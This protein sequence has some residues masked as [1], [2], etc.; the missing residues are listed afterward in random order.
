MS[1]P[2]PNILLIIADDL[3]FSDLG[4]FGSEIKTPNLDRLAAKQGSVRL[5]QFHT[6]S[7]CSPTRSML[8]SGTDHHLAGLGQ[9]A[10]VMQRESIYDDEEGKR[11][12]GYE[13]VL[14]DRVA[15][16]PELLADTHHTW[17]AGKW[18]L[19]LTPETS[20]HARSFHRSYTLLPGA[21]NHYNYT[22]PPPPPRP[23]GSPGFQFIPP[24]YMEDDKVLDPEKDLPKPFYSSDVFVDQWLRFY[25]ELREPTHPHHHR[26]WCSLLTFTAPHWPLQADPADV[27]VYKG[28]YDAGPLALR[29]ARLQ[30][31]YETGLIPE[32][33]LTSARDV[34]FQFADRELEQWSDLTPSE[35][36]LSARSMETYAAMVTRMDTAIGRVLDQLE[37]DG[38]LENTLVFFA[39]DNGAE[40]A[41]LEAMPLS[42]GNFEKYIRENYDNSL[43]NVGRANSF[44]WYGPLW[45]QA[46]TAPAA[47][48]K[49]WI[50]E[51]GI[52]CPAILHYPPLLSSRA[53]FDPHPAASSSSSSPPPNESKN[54]KV[55]HAL[56]TVMDLLPTILDLSSLPHPY[57]H[58]FRSRP[59][60]PLRGLSL[61][62]LLRGDTQSEIHDAESEAIGWELFGQQAVRRGRW[63][64]VFVPR[65]A[66]LERWQLF[67]L[68]G[69]PGEGC[70]LAEREPEVLKR[71]I[72]DWTVYESEVGVILPRPGTDDLKNGYG[73]R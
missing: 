5:T 46:A 38:V 3:G 24:L 67:D 62:P 37:R 73:P 55:C 16:M 68:E 9:M 65:P 23:D 12:P 17:I 48:Y 22:P 64:A 36:A 27:E 18:H 52:R 63:K 1:P 2:S 51:G 71:L 44:V 19:G 11:K 56:M 13:G 25:H 61:V 66:G 26:P 29:E 34:R 35:R 47:Q 45:A 6:A 32:S 54:G 30:G 43:E 42:G 14:N 31:L 60:L 72:E 41:L 21:G 7:A 58:T 40:G 57:P 69:D 8:L 10:E 59:I 15:A 20:P 28:K 33:H 53:P 49:A 70:D 4:C 39:A 50:T